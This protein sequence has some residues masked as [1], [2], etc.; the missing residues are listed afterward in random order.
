MGISISESA[1]VFHVPYGPL[2][3]EGTPGAGFVDVKSKPDLVPMVASCLGWPETQ[4][5]LR[6]V[7]APGSPLMTLAADQAFTA[8]DH[9]ELKSV[10]TS[11]V[12]LCYADVARNGKQTLADL[13]GSLGKRIT[14]LL[15]TASN[16]LQ[17]TL[18]LNVTLKLQPTIFHQN[19][20]E[21][22]SLTVLMAAYGKNEIDAR[23]TWG[24]GV[25]VLQEALS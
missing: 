25:K 12:T 8:A 24:V 17:R 19:N 4:N 11:F 3:S 9:R 16:E 20:V 18:H 6:A 13:A 23:I 2:N 7:N 22:W 21:G 1:A 14:E 15:Q 10:L 5:L